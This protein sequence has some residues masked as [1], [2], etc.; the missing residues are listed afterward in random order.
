MSCLLLKYFSIDLFVIFMVKIECANT[1][2]T[3]D[4]KSGCFER[5]LSVCLIYLCTRTLSWAGA[6]E[7]IC[8]LQCLW[9]VPVYRGVHCRDGASQL[10]NT[11][12]LCYSSICSPYFGRICKDFCSSEMSIIVTICWPWWIALFQN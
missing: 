1:D 5:Y 9:L 3:V 8:V 12:W 11:S 10:E 7:S 2:K 6:I 4:E